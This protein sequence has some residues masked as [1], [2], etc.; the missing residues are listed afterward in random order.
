MRS[1]NPILL[2]LAGC[3][4]LLG[5]V[6][7]LSPLAISSRLPT[8]ASTQYAQATYTREEVGDK[9]IDFSVDGRHECAQSIEEP[10]RLTLASSFADDIGVE[11]SPLRLLMHRRISPASPDDAFHLA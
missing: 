5:P 1:G 3:I 7:R 10:T 6:Q 2:F 4:I 9:G 8:L 11:V